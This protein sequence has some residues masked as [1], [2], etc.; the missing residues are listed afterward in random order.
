VVVSSNLTG[1]IALQRAA[2]ARFAG[3]PEAAPGRGQ[4]WPVVSFACVFT[5]AGPGGTADRP[6][7]A[8]ALRPGAG[9]DAP[10]G[11]AGL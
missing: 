3:E 11:F 2:R 7:E 10:R 4:P 1:G 8:A 9:A 5:G 6:R